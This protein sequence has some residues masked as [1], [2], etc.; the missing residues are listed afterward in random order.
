MSGDSFYSQ[1]AGTE[2]PPQPKERKVNWQANRSDNEMPY[3]Q[4]TPRHVKEA[5]TVLQPNLSYYA[6]N[7]LAFRR[8]PVDSFEQA[9]NIKFGSYATES[10]FIAERERYIQLYINMME[11]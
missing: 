3:V 10:N 1:F 4:D 2:A 6:F 7:R 11:Q 8:Q 5:M 9:V